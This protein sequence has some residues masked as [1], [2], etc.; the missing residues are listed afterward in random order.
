[1]AFRVSF[2][3]VALKILI[4]I[5][6]II[7]SLVSRDVTPSAWLAGLKTTTNKQTKLLLGFFLLLKI[8]DTFLYF[9]PS[10]KCSSELSQSVDV[11]WLQMFPSLTCYL[12]GRRFPV[13]RP[14][15]LQQKQRQS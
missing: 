4:I 10:D 3:D 14:F 6:I 12:A 2:I 5:V 15:T 11:S 7:F 13:H 9:K 8:T 1:M